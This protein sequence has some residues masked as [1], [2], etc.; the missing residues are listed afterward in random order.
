MGPHQPIPERLQSGGVV[1]ER[2]RSDPAFPSWPGMLFLEPS[3]S[4][5]F[6]EVGEPDKFAAFEHFLTPANGLSS[7]LRGIRLVRVRRSV[8]FEVFLESSRSMLTVGV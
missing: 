4:A 3:K 2:L 7:L 5:F 6:L 1:I 8:R